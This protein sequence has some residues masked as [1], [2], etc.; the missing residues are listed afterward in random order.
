[1]KATTLTEALTIML[2]DSVFGIF[3]SLRDAYMRLFVKQTPSYLAYNVVWFTNCT[4]IEQ[5]YAFDQFDMY[6]DNK[7]DSYEKLQH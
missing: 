7:N 4:W 6:L 5:L 2:Q 1:M 3:G